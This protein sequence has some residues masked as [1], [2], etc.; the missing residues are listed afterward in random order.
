MPRDDGAPAIHARRIRHAEAFGLMKQGQWFLLGHQNPHWRTALALC[1]GALHCR[2]AFAKWIQGSAQ[3]PADAGGVQPT[4]NSR[5]DQGL[6][7]P[8]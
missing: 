3:G 4:D 1:T 2:P 5:K 7:E 6:L 8:G